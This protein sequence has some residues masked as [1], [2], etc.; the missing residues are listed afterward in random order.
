[1]YASA[2]L[3]CYIRTVCV[4]MCVTWLYNGWRRG[5]R[6]KLSFFSQ[7]KLYLLKTG[8][9]LNW[10]VIMINNDNNIY[11]TKYTHSHFMHS[12]S[13]L[14]GKQHWYLQCF[15]SVTSHPDPPEVHWLSDQLVVLRHLFLGGKLHEA[16]TDL[17][18]QPE[19]T[20]PFFK[21]K[22]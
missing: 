9:S 8:T 20:R 4:C 11:N 5:G 3:S 15:F 2:C 19:S 16:F 13:R 1:M 6:N 10:M 17:S 12:V 22:K 18:T 21:K 14:S 7:K